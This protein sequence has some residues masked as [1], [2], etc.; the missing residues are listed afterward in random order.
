VA[1][2]RGRPEW[3]EGVGKRRHD[4]DW[5]GAAY[6]EVDENQCDVAK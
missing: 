6:A 1:T 5:A 2:Q 4:D 3:A